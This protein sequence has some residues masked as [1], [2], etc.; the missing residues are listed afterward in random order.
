VMIAIDPELADEPHR[1]QFWQ[2]RPRQEYLVAVCAERIDAGSPSLIVRQAIP[3]ES[4][5]TLVPEFLRVS[6]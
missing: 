1:W 2:F 5:K 4:E 6:E 3:M